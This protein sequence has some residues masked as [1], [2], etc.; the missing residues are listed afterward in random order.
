MSV[1]LSH[2]TELQSGLGAG[3]S[4]SLS[5]T[6]NATASQ[7]VNPTDEDEEISHISMFLDLS[8]QRG[9]RIKDGV[10]YE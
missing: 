10:S 7:M 6:V 4:L 2:L 5:A 9:G 1:S 3:E 8:S